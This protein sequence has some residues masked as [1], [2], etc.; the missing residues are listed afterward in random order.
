MLQ[1][2]KSGLQ[3]QDEEK[4]ENLSLGGKVVSDKK[5][6]VPLGDSEIWGQEHATIGRET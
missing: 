4:N 2:M 3:D 5:V 6:D 1:K